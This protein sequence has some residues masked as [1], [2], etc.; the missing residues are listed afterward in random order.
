MLVYLFLLHTF[1][2]HTAKLIKYTAIIVQVKT[3]L[4]K[5]RDL[6]PFANQSKIKRFLLLS[7]PFLL[8]NQDPMICDL[9]ITQRFFV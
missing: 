4:Y 1:S 2:S 6:V 5:S 7:F 9:Y 8:T 3:I